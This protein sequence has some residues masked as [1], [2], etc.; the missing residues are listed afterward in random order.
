MAATGIWW[1]KYP[2]A[3]TA[4]IDSIAVMPFVDETGNAENDLLA[5]GMTESLINSL[6]R[7]PNLSV[8]ARYSVFSYKGKTIKSGPHRK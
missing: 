3:S 5:D 8:K 6:S 7:L 2:A 1:W 4:H